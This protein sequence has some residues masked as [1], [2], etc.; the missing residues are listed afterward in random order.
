MR[1]ASRYENE[2]RAGQPR[3]RDESEIAGPGSSRRSRRVRLFRIMMLPTVALL[4]L[5]VLAAVHIAGSNNGNSMPTGNP[6]GWHLVY[7]QDFNG[8][9]LPPSWTAYTGEPGGDPEGYWDPANVT[10]SGGELHFR[11]T[12]D[13]DPNHPGVS[14]TGGAGFYGHPQ[15]YGMYLV[16]FKG[17]YEPGLKISDIA[18]LWPNGNN[19]WPPEMDFF[20]DS[21]GDRSLYTATLHPGP[22]GDDCCMARQ[23]NKNAATQWHTYGIKWTPTTITYTI[24][25]KPWGNVINRDEISSPAQWPSIDMNLDLQSQNLGSAQPSRPIETMTVAWVVE[26][27]LGSK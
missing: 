26:Y 27:A 2:I 16:R 4:V 8:T 3:D 15:K 23:Y 12:P 5:L 18:L 19:I 1:Y 11:T 25:G 13:D 14:S 22:D 9:S 7:S 10:V 20:E 17:D 24:D 21:G 6:P